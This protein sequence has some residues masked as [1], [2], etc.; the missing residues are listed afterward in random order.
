VR[1]LLVNGQIYSPAEN[2]ATAILIENDIIAWIGSEGGADVHRREVDDVIDVAG[3]LITPGFV[4]LAADAVN[5]PG[6]FVHAELAEVPI[7]DRWSEQTWEDHSQR[8]V[9]VVPRLPCRL[10]SRISKG[11][12][13][14]LV[15]S[16]MNVSGWQTV[17]SAIYDVEP[18]ERLTARG[19]FNAMT[20]SAWRILGWPERGVLAVGAEA[21]FVRWSTDDLVIETPDQRISNWS[22]DPRAATPGLPPLHPGAELP[23]V[24]GVWLAGVSQ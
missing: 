15:P 1:T 21:T 18:A 6:G 16:V 19:A 14:A 24:S 7:A 23:E 2:F 9:A 12:P 17:R 4:N 20:R 8:A 5:L 22:T 10:R 11:T 3:D 13:T